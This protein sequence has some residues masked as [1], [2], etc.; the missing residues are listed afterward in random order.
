MRKIILLILII[1]VV[2]SC[3]DKVVKQPDNLLKLE[4]MEDII[5]D[6]AVIEAIKSNDP[7]LLENNNIDPNNYI[8][9]KYKIDSLQ[10]VQNNTYYAVD[11]KKYSE[12]FDRVEKRLEQSKKEADSLLILSNQPILVNKVINDTVKKV[13]KH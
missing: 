6:L 7:A 4:T 10:F 13:K 12:L 3:K 9:K 1:I 11:I 8:Y 5:Y 2:S